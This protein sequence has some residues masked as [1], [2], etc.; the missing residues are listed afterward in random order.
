MTL[1]REST[2]I[3]GGGIMGLS[4][5]WALVRR[6][7][8]VTVLEQGSAPN[9][10]ASSV[11]QHRAIR[12][13]YGSDIGYMRMVAEAYPM[14]DRLWG[15]LGVRHYAETGTLM[16]EVGDD[17]WARRSVEAMTADGIPVETVNKTEAAS[18]WPMLRTDFD[19]AIH[20]SPTGGLLFAEPIVRAMAAWLDNHVPEAK[21]HSAAEVIEV[22]PEL[23]RVT[24]ADGR[25]LTAD[26]LVVAA[27]PWTPRLL[28]ELA[29]E[30][31]PSRQVPSYFIPPAHFAQA[32]ETA[33]LILDIGTDEGFYVV[34]PANGTG[35]KLGCHSFSLTGDPDAPRVATEADVVAVQAAA[36][37]CLVDFNGYRFSHARVC[38]YS[39]AGQERF[40]VRPLTAAGDGAVPGCWVLGGFSGHGFKFG[41]LIGERVAAALCGEIAPDKVAAW[42]AGQA[43]D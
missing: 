7:Q 8:Q 5:A 16:M 29:R 33:P 15:D 42:A 9:A 17:S 36:A 2:L 37:S 12:Y 30:I 43:P 39:V 11:D 31:T 24:L 32:W 4:V 40:V 34:P 10:L 23:R 26:R 3:V 14:W 19:G 18:R 25:I 28:P 1:Q 21:L 38:Y 41:P 22:D 13:A 20:H 27:G 35:L 6:G